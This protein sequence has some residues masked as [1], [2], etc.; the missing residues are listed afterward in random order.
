MRGLGV[1]HAACGGRSGQQGVGLGVAVLGAHEFQ[2]NSPVGVRA[3]TVQPGDD[4]VVDEKDRGED[5]GVLL[6]G[7][8][9]VDLPLVDFFAERGQAFPRRKKVAEAVVEFGVGGTE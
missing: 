7:G 1:P 4:G 3:V 6:E 2:R 8:L 5:R 9:P